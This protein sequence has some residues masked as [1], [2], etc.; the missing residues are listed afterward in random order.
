MLLDLPY[1]CKMRPR[2]HGMCPHHACGTWGKS[3]QPLYVPLLPSRSVVPPGRG[4]WGGEDSPL[5]APS[6]QPE[7]SLGQ[8]RLQLRK[9]GLHVGL[10]LYD[11]I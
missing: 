7:P 6:P 4:H 9:W 3:G 2:E 11:V 8:G 10:A 1:L 5:C